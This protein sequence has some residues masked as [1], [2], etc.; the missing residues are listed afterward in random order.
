MSTTISDPVASKASAAAHVGASNLASEQFF[1]LRANDVAQ[2]CHTMA[3]RFQDGGRLLAFGIGAQRSDVAHV[4][5][6]FVHPVIVGKRA[7]P[8]LALPEPKTLD[9]LARAGDMLIVFCGSAPTDVEHAVLSTAS[10]RG[11]VTLALTGA[12]AQLG[13]DF[14]FAVPSSD[15]LIVQ[16]THEMLYHVLWE[17]VHVFF[18]HRRGE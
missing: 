14:H 2:A 17:L 6:E 15:P 18:E 7:L 10:A 8:A 3:R 5:V 4:V 13:A 11:M 9:T 16:E 1:A 12:T